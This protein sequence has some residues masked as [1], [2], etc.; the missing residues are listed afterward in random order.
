[1]VKKS[2]IDNV[3]I[4]RGKQLPDEQYEFYISLLK[5]LE[6]MHDTPAALLQTTT[7]LVLMAIQNNEL[8]RESKDIAIK[9]AITSME[10]LSEH[11]KQGS[12]KDA[13]GKVVY[14]DIPDDV[15]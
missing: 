6:T 8:D 11:L 5:F 12:P 15:H 7:N 13:T 9:S 2:T 4:I 10:F 1:M 3:K 14:S